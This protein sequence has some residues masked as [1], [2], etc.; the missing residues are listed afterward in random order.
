MARRT[1]TADWPD[2]FTPRHGLGLFLVDID[3]LGHINEAHGR[4]LG[5]AVLRGVADALRN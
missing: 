4:R 2:H 5:D 1:A 3:G